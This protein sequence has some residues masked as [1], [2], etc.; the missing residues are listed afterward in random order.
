MFGTESAILSDVSPLSDFAGGGGEFSGVLCSSFVTSRKELRVGVCASGSGA[1]G[2][3]FRNRSGTDFFLS[4][5]LTPSDRLV[6]VLVCVD[7]VVLL[8]VL[9]FETGLI[10]FRLLRGRERAEPTSDSSSSVVSGADR[11]FHLETRCSTGPRRSVVNADS[12]YRK[13]RLNVDQKNS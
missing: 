3:L 2:A 7:D 4:S 10:R 11:V 8:L 12:S 13:I 6:G 9:D 1:A 5:L